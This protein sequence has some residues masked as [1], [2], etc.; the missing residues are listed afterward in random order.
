MKFEAV[1]FIAQAIGIVAVAVTFVSYQ[2]KS[3]GKI[4]FINGIATLLFAVHYLMLKAY[5]A[6]IINFF[7]IIRNIV[8]GFSDRVPLFG[9]KPVPYLMGAIIVGLGLLSWTGWESIIITVALMLNTVFMSLK[10]PQ[11]LRMSLILTCTMV[12]VYNVIVM[13]Y[14]GI[15]NEIIAMASATIGLVRYRQKTTMIFG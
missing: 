11:H 4:L 10:N 15:L 7:G 13:S 9:K 6:S 14:G 1:E 3:R 12:L 5:P 2:V 8:Y